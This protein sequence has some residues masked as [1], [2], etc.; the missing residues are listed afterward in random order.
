[1]RKLVFFLFLLAN[2]GL[3]QELELISMIELPGNYARGIDVQDGFAYLSCEQSYADND[4]ILMIFDVSDIYTPVLVSTSD[5]TENNYGQDIVV[6]EDY[7]Y[8]ADNYS[9]IQ[10]FNVSSPTEP[11]PIT[12]VPMSIGLHTIFIDGDLLYTAKCGA[13]GLYIIDIVDPENP[14]ILSH[15][16]DYEYGDIE[17]IYVEFPYAHFVTLFGSF[18][19]V[20]IAD[21]YNPLIVGSLFGWP[22]RFF[23]VIVDGDYAYTSHDYSVLE[24]FDISDPTEPTS[25]TEF[26]NNWLS[27]RLFKHNQYLF[28]AGSNHLTVFDVS[29]P[30]NPVVAAQSEGINHVDVE[31]IDGIVYTCGTQYFAIYSFTTTG[32]NENDQP[33]PSRI[34]LLSNYPNPFNANTTITFRLNE[35]GFANLSMY[36]LRGD[37]IRTLLDEFIQAGNHDIYFNAAGL[38][39]GVYYYKLQA[40]DYTESK[41]MVLLK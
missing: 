38:A 33:M 25:I 19:V 1:M 17:S 7:A 16:D 36:D 34:E 2:A 20:N 30:S 40:G 4:T 14:I 12:I 3:C 11:R 15:P 21:P 31:V 5:T 13:G 6:V 22:T 24:I 23:D 18:T 8:V 41:S 32:I 29:D 35:K 26:S 39:S 9:G 37:K 27:S 10:I 28:V